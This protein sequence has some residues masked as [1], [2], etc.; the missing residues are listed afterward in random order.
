[1]VITAT[2]LTIKKVIKKQWLSKKKKKNMN[3]FFL[4]F[5]FYIFFIL[6]DDK[7]F[8]R[9]LYLETYSIDGDDEWSNIN[10]IRN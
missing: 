8:D 5:F 2:I 1:M 4:L 3:A 9:K 10:G 6:I 7:G